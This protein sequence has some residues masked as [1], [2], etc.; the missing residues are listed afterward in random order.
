M[1]SWRKKKKFSISQVKKKNALSGVMSA[2]LILSRLSKIDCY[3]S[4]KALLYISCE[5]FARLTIHI[6]CQVLSAVV[7]IGALKAKILYCFQPLKHQSQLQQTT[8]L[9]IFFNFS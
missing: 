5:S 4:E 7:G 8:V 6:K 3:F 2:K 9:Y 1:F